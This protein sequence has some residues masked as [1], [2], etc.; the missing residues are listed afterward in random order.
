MQDI[1]QREE[2]AKGKEARQHLQFI[3]ARTDHLDDVLAALA[4]LKTTPGVDAKR[5][6]IVGHSFGGQLTLL[7][8]ERDKSVRAAVT[9]A[10]AANSW[11][12]SHELPKQLR[13]AVDNAT[14]PIMLIQAANDYSTAPSQELADELRRLHKSCV[15]KIYPPVGRTA[16]DGHNFLYLAIPQWEHDVFNFLNA[17]L[18]P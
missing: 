10:A 15:L 5:I 17:H 11:K 9:F 7:A 14:A 1:L 4:F 8:A 3:L 6:A 16:D 13:V 2:A 18:R 12:H